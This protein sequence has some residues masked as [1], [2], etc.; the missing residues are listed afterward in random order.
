MPHFRVDDALH[1]HPKARQ[2]GLEAMGL[3]AACGSYCMGYLTDGF[4]PEWY[5][6]T[7]PKGAAVAKKLV[8]AKMWH[9]AE[10]D[11]EKG[12]QFHEFT[13]PGR[14]DSRA[15]IEES[16]K[17]WRDKKAGQRGD[18]PPVSPGDTRGE[19]PGEAKGESPRDSLRATRDPTQ[20]IKELSGYVHESATD[21]NARDAIAATPAADLVRRAV[22]RELNS[23]IQTQLRLSAG[24]LLHDGTP[25]D[26][27]EAA[28]AEWVTKT[29]IGPGVLPSLAADVVKRRNGHAREGP[30]P[31]PHKL[32]G[33]AELAAQERA[34]EQSQL[35]NPTARKELR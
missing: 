5:V 19:S 25:P 23:A 8:A 7:W 9:P 21:S 34:R 10:R 18:S 6:K 2:A 27:V 14:N 16:R 29:G 17:K 28:L 15:Q 26:V 3:W 13:G 4:V 12:W 24:R 11:G 22:P 20:P 1:S 31:K 32:R 35:E 30:N 33:F